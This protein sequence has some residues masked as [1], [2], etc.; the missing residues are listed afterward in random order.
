MYEHAF[1]PITLY[2]PMQVFKTA[3]APSASIGAPFV[4]DGDFLVRLVTDHRSHQAILRA[5]ADGEFKNLENLLRGKHQLSTKTMSSLSGRLNVTS[6]ELATW[7]HGQ[8]RGPLAPN[9]LGIF[10][11]LE[12]VPGALASQV[13]ATPVLCRCCGAN[14]LDDRDVFW[15]RQQVS[16]APAEYEFAERL[17]RASVGA[18]RVF[19]VIAEIVGKTFSWDDLTSL[20][21]PSKYPMGH[22]LELMQPHYQASSLIEL[23]VKMQLMPAAECRV[24]YERLKKWSSGKDLM[25][26]AIARRLIEG[27]SEPNRL[28]LRFMLA[29]TMTFIIDFLCSAG[30]IKPTRLQAQEIVYCR[31]NMLV[32]NMR[33]AIIEERKKATPG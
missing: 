29:R 21:H 13:L 10:A 25:P 6:E 19:I 8:E 30:P 23:S 26:V 11:L 22:W 18:A 24:P 4:P 20:A 15:G 28:W 16:Y 14:M 12:T 31:V 2:R 32:A 3:L 5:E 9:V 27:T 1:A 7:V 17:L 33:T